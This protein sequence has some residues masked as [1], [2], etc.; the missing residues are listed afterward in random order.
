ML[1]FGSIP[2][3]KQE[4]GGF[5]HPPPSFDQTYIKKIESLCE[6][7]CPLFR[8]HLLDRQFVANFKF[9]GCRACIERLAYVSSLMRNS[10]HPV[11]FATVISLMTIITPI[12][13]P[14]QTPL[15]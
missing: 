7:R 6:L 10:A 2:L 15:L 9:Y 3:Q 4:A 8:P 12:T 1:K 14:S 13:Y 5:F 11:A